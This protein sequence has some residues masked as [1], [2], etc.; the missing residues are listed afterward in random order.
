MSITV[1]T[2][3]KAIIS[4]I[5][6]LLFLVNANLILQLFGITLDG[7]GLM[8][9]RILGGV[10]LGLGTS[11]Y[12]IKGTADIS[13][14]SAKLYSFSEMLAAVACLIATLNGDMNMAGWILVV[15]YAFFSLC[16]IWV[17]KVVQSNNNL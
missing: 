7:A 1:F 10:Y 13:T 14:T 2:K 3:P 5:V 9:A 8:I 4:I 17:A 15:A 16:F 11:F 12:L 6:A